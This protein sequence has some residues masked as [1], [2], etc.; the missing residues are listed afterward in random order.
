MADDKVVVKVKGNPAVRVAEDQTIVKDIRVGNPIRRIKQSKFHASSLG[1]DSVGNALLKEE[2]GVVV[3]TTDIVPDVNAQ[4]NLGSPT[5]KFRGLYIGAN[6]LYIGNLAISEDSYGNA[7]ISSVDSAGFVIA[8]TTKSIA[9]DLDSNVINNLI[10]PRI[11]SAVEAV[12]GGAPEALDTLFELAQ[13]LGND[14]NAFGTLLTSINQKL[15]SAQV[16]GLID[17]AYVSTLVQDNIGGVAVDL[18]T[19]AALQTID[20]FPVTTYRSVKYIVQLEHDSDSKYHCAE[21]LLTH[22]GINAYLTEYAIVYTDSSLGE[23]DATVDAGNVKLQLTPSY[24][25]TSFKAKRISVSA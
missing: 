17:S 12:I 19:T 6:T 20:E 15:D 24:T 9:T 13:S 22:N 14:S 5:N 23:F 4:Y 25:N 21:I 11:D 3:V 2:N 18:T 10:Q 8:G 1:G 16:V 7:V